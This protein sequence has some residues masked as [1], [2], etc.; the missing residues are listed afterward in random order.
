ML[1]SLGLCILAVLISVGCARTWN[2]TRLEKF[3][4]EK[5]S[6]SALSCKE[7]HQVEYGTWKMTKHAGSSR[8]EKIPLEQF[9]ECAACHDNL[10]SHVDEPGVSMPAIFPEMEKTKQNTICGKCHYNQDLLG[11]KAINPGDKHGLF[12]SV[13]FEDRKRQISCLDCHSGHKGKS[14]MLRSIRAHTCFSCHKEAI[15]TMG[16]FQPFNYLFFGKVCLGCHPPHGGSTKGTVARMAT[17][18]MLTCVVCH[19]PGL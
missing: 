11:K 6:P 4:A 8:M 13:G 15:V 16:V 18:T 5:D 9:R 19:P 2:Y 3:N 14:D 17:G 1:R 7:C 10:A 12:M